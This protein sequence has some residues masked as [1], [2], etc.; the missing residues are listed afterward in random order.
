MKGKRVL[1]RKRNPLWVILGIGLAVLLAAGI[2]VLKLSGAAGKAPAEAEELTVSSEEKPM[3]TEP[4]HLPP[5][6]E[7][8]EGP[9][10]A[11][12]TSEPE[13]QDRFVISL[14]G[15]C[16]LSSSHYTNH[17]ESLVGD[18]LEY[19]FSNVAELLTADDLTLANLEC[20]FSDKRLESNSTYAFCGRPQYARSLVL[21]GVDC[22]SM[23]NNHTNDFGTVG[24]TDTAAALEDVGVTGIQGDRGM[25]FDLRHDDGT[26]VRIGIYVLAFNGSREQMKKGVARLQEDGAD[27]VIACMHTGAERIYVPTARQTNL[28]HAAIQG[29]ADVVVGTHPHILQPAEA[30]QGGVILYSI[31]NFCFGGNKNPSD[32]DTMIFQQTFTFEN[33]NLLD[34]GNI[35]IIP[36]SLSSSSNKNDYKPRIL[37][38]SEKDR[39][40][41]KI[42]D[43]SDLS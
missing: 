1:R 28:A 7:E 35:K 43:M 33:G 22:V 4:D 16:T 41:K 32:K 2:A 26:T 12:D 18:D 36:C 20:T 23:A 5:E 14:L 13:K 34:D 29:G 21:G 24:V 6:R 17:F 3:N 19:P 40:M 30:Y 8:A 27:I 11:E 25:C 9:E 42:E 39:V 10:I 31:G 15:D 37:E 38:G